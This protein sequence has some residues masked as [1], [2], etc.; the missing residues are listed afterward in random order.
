MNSF[1]VQH[2]ICVVGLGLIGGSLLRD[3]AAREHPVYGY[4]HS[5]SGARTAI[6][7]GFDVTDDLPGV[8]QRAEEDRALL[9]VAVPVHAVA[10]VLDAIDQHAPHCG[11]TDVVSVKSVVYEEVKK[12]GLHTRYVGGHPMAVSPKAG[13]RNSRKDLFVRKA[14]AITYDYALEQEEA[15]ERIEQTWIDTFAEVVRMTGMVRAEAVPARVEN[16][17]AAVA[18]VSYLPQILA[19][20]LSM[21]GD[22]GGI[23]AQSLTAGP[24]HDATR[25]AGTT[26]KIVRE[27]CESNA[28]ALVDALDETLSYLQETR[29]NLAAAAPTIGELADVGHRARTR[30]EARSGARKDSV[31]PIKISSRPVLRLQP[32]GHGWVAQLKQTESI[33]GRIEIF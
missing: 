28:A 5:T 3:L 12:R 16:H 31:S 33:G 23:L 15:G 32:G 18:R 24:F 2:P 17:D 21:V 27:G 13:W 20:V 30:I 26:P 22:N 25:A 8:L 19:E 29:D 11:I 1:D 7:E 9:V 4:N 14:W 6:K 10:D